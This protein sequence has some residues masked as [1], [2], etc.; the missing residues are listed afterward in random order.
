[1]VA[2][3]SKH[4]NKSKVAQ[5]EQV[6]SKQKKNNAGGYTF[7]VDLWNR[8]NRFLILGSDKGSYYVD[9][10]RHT[11]DNLKVVEDAV[12]ADPA[13]TVAAIVDVSDKGRA[14]K[15]SPAILALAVCASSDNLEARRLALEALPKVVRTGT[16][17]FEFVEYVNNLRGWGRALR[18]AISKWYGEKSLDQLQYH[19]VKYQSRNGWSNRDVLRLCHVK[20]RDSERNNVYRWMVG[21]DAEIKSGLIYGK[22]LI[23]NA[24]SVKTAIKIID[25]YKLPREAVPTKFLKERE[26]WEHL[27]KDMPYTATLRNLG[28]MSARGMLENLSDSS[29]LVVERLTDAEYIKKSRVHPIDVLLAL[30]TYSKGSGFRSSSSWD[31]HS[32]IVDALDTAF[33]AAFDNVE[34][35]G[36]NTLV[37]LDVSGSMGGGFYGNQNILSPREI[38]A[39]FAMVFMRTEP[40]TDIMA[41]SDTFMPLNITKK[42][43]LEKVLKKTSG[44]SFRATDCSLP[45]QWASSREAKFESFIV[46]TDNETYAGSVHPHIA[47]K[48][49]RKKKGVDARLAVLATE[50]TEFTI[51]DPKDPGMLDVAGFDSTV[52]Q[53][54]SEFFKGNV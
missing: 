36:K 31:V 10:A 34:P 1:M 8:L 42:D 37:A 20:T 30:R 6:D 53:V 46:I 54:L 18:Q 5:T 51:A 23:D 33:Y 52:P 49:Y 3:Y 27:L 12:K 35:T 47:L 43:T 40:N 14:P 4:V 48:D 15:N 2:P 29:K 26:V 32:N 25:E 17:L 44:L 50:S 19:A 16:H 24:D 39:A 21:K 9:A 7:T 22:S 41:F 13:R 38:A 28:T 45:M 11:K